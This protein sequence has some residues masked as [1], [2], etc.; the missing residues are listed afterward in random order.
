LQKQ[1]DRL[2]ADKDQAAIES[3]GE[4]VSKVSQDVGYFPLLML[5]E[6]DPAIAKPPPPKDEKEQKE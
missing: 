1:V 4:E 2:V 6:E 5:G 3:I